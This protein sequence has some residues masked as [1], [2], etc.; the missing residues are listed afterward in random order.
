MRAGGSWAT[1]PCR[2]LPRIAGYIVIRVRIRPAS[3]GGDTEARTDRTILEV[4]GEYLRG[5]GSRCRA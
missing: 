4:P 2:G 1:R 5:P 3:D